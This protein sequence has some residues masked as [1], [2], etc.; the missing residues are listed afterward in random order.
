MSHDDSDRPPSSRAPLRDFHVLS[1][2]GEGIRV[3]VREA[4][5]PALEEEAPEDAT[6]DLDTMVVPENQSK[7]ERD[8]FV[9]AMDAKWGNLI[10]KELS[11]YD[12]IL[13]EST[14]DLKQRVLLV[15]CRYRE[16]DLLDPAK[17]PAFLCSVVE[18]TVQNHRR[19]GQ[20]DIARGANAE[21]EPDD[22]PTPDEALERAELWRLLSENL[23]KLPSEEAEAFEAHVLHGMTFRAIGDMVHRSDSTIESRYKRALEKLQRLANAPEQAPPGRRRRGR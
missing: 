3:I 11:R 21:A 17:V 4:P 20:L 7:A 16:R 10:R 1:P 23:K 22:A 6:G 2:A 12:D 14:K 19:R 5:P 18:K 8:A 13:A 15:L 9:A